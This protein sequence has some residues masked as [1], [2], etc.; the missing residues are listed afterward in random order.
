MNIAGE[1][2][3]WFPFRLPDKTLSC[4]TAALG[5]LD[6]AQ[7]G[8]IAFEAD[9]MRAQVVKKVFQCSRHGF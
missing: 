5:Y 7:V 1:G 2:A 6:A 3:V 4:K 8:L 9:P